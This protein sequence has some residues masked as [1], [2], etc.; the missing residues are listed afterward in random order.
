M[1]P[2]V[3]LFCS[4]S[5]AYEF[6][7][8]SLYYIF[9]DSPWISFMVHH[10][11]VHSRIGNPSRAFP[12]KQLGLPDFRPRTLFHEWPPPPPLVY[13]TRFCALSTHSPVI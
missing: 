7:H 5:R 8:G 6:F 3:L 9:L 1:I 11:K 13:K 10:S 2:R 12:L 4:L